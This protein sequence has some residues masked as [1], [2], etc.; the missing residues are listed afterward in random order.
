[1]ASSPMPPPIHILGA[2]LS[3]LTI[4]RALL[5][6]GVP[7]IIYD[8][9]P[10]PARRPRFNYGITLKAETFETVFGLVYPSSGIANG[11][12]TR[13]FA[14]LV[15]VDH[16][17]G[18]VGSV[19]PGKG[20]LTGER[21]V[22][23]GRLEAAMQE[24]LD[25]KW[26]SKLESI[27]NSD[28]S[29]TLRFADGKTVATPFLIVADGIHSLVRSSMLP[30]KKADVVPYV[31]FR[32]ARYISR[33]T[34]TDVYSKA[35][36]GANIIE[37]TTQEGT[38]L[39]ISIDS[40]PSTSKGTEV[41]DISYIYSRPAAT[42]DSLFNQSRSTD[43]AKDVPAE[44]YTELGRLELDGPFADTFSPD[45]VKKDRVL[46]W[47][48]RTLVVEAGDLKSLAS[49][50][51]LLV[52]EAACAGPILGSEGATWVV[53]EGVRVAGAVS[54]VMRSEVEGEGDSWGR[55]DYEGLFGNRREAEVKDAVKRL[56]SM[57]R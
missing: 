9:S 43:G 33:Q 48:M 52:G 15:S 42:T 56:E 50:G 11:E 30:S 40:L 7:S 25:I 10:N 1:M 44:F 31:V 24:G 5:N 38:R 13:K 46:H 19:G 55:L 28:K 26:E 20:D 45:N 49:E 4:A 14:E 12:E 3:G 22:N 8:R 47:L 51:V 36:N 27:S 17:G 32:G 29:S 18:A 34:Y 57:H 41:V 39:Q 54:A 21:R 16:K 23:R 6:R 53:E 37:K 2:G 35:F